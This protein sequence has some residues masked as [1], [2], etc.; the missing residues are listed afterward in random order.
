[1]KTLISTALT[2]SLLLPSACPAAFEPL[3]TGARSAAL[4]GSALALHGDLI[5]GAVNPAGLAGLRGPAV[6]AWA[7]PSL[8]GIEGLNRTGCAAG[9]P[10]ASVPV[11]LSVSTL[12]LRSYKET[13]VAFSAAFATGASWAAG[14]RLRLEM[15]SIEGYGQAAVPALDA[16]FSCTVL[17]GCIVAILLANAGGARIGKSEESIPQSLSFGCVWAPGPADVAVYAR[18]AKEILSPLEWN[19]GVEYAI[20]PGFMIRTGFSTE[21]SLLCG[22]FGIHVAPVLLEYGVAHHWQLGETHYFSVSFD[23]E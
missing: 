21:P 1:M 16:G 12:G 23:F 22:G 17:P 19:L 7:T 14:V 8:F 6:A 18:C 4:G 9:L 20:I 11:S 15:L 13:S 3:V 2:L 5:A 10:I